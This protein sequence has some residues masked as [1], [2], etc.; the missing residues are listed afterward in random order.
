MQLFL[1]K[2]LLLATHLTLSLEVQKG[3]TMVNI[4]FV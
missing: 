4:K 1:D 3:Q 2:V